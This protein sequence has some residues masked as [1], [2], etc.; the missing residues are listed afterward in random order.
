MS[1]LHFN[2]AW[3]GSMRGLGPKSVRNP[4]NNFHFPTQR[5]MIKSDKSTKSLKW[6]LG[7]FVSDV[8]RVSLLSLSRAGR[9]LGCLRR[10]IHFIAFSSLRRLKFMV[11][12]QMLPREICLLDPSSHLIPL[13]H[14][15]THKAILPPAQ[16][17]TRQLYAR[18]YSC[19][20]GPSCQAR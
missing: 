20:L 5:D 3:S 8:G 16:C 6:A 1:K 18:L 19:K 7:R 10:W 4:C 15:V 13:Q 14:Q 11:S 2:S 9:R 12:N 17:V